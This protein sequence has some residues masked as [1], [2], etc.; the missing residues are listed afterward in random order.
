MSRNYTTAIDYWGFRCPKGGD[1]YICENAWIEFIGCCNSDP[2]ADGTGICQNGVEPLSFDRKNSYKLPLQTCLSSS[3]S[4]NFYLCW[5][6]S[7]PFMGCC[8]QNACGNGCPAAQPGTALLSLNETSRRD[9]FYP[10]SLSLPVPPSSKKF[11][12]PPST[13]L[14]SSFKSLEYDAKSSRNG[15]LMQ[16]YAVHKHVFSSIKCSVHKRKKG[17]AKTANEQTYSQIGNQGSDGSDESMRPSFTPSRD[18]AIVADRRFESQ[19][20]KLKQVDVTTF[21]V[22]VWNIVLTLV[23][24]CFIGR[25]YKNLARYCLEQSGGVRLVVLEQ[26]FGSQSFATALERVF[27]VHTHIILSFIIL[28]TWT[29]SPLGGQSSSRILGFGNATEVANGTVNYLHPA[30]QVSSYLARRS[31]MATKSSVAALYSS[32]LLSSLEQKCSPRDMWE[33]PKIPQIIGYRQ[34][35]K[36]YMVDREALESGDQH[37]ASLLGVQLRGL[38]PSQEATEHNFTVQTSYID[39]DCKLIDDRFD[40]DTDYWKNKTTSDRKDERV[41]IDVQ[42]PLPWE[43]LDGL[44]DPPPLQLLYFS[45]WPYKNG[46][47][48]FTWYWSAMNCTM[49]TIWLETD[50]HCGQRPSSTSCHAHQQRQLKDIQHANRPPRLMGQNYGA[51]QQALRFWP[52]ASG[53]G[54][55]DG[56]LATENYIMGELHPYAGHP[57]RNWTALDLTIFPKEVSKRLTTAFNTFWDATLNPLGHT[58]VSFGALNS[59]NP[60]YEDE[61]N[62]EPFMNATVGTMTRTFEVYRASQLWVAILLT[63][64]MFLQI[65]AILGLILEAVIVGPE[66]LGFA[67]SLTR[68]NPY[69]PVPPGNSAVGGAERARL[70]R[71]LRLQIADLELGEENGYIAVHALQKSNVEKVSTEDSEEQTGTDETSGQVHTKPLGRGR[72]YR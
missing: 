44:D 13:L 16:T 6:T 62:P 14:P 12:K 37:Y 71:D 35:R 18:E 25:F 31:L 57:Y 67:S 42:S 54:G 47:N 43:E 68:D 19:P 5:G 10:S 9:L 63:T 20:R 30:Y 64:T 34:V 59:S 8:G 17:P 53:D 56:P 60:A 70:F 26:I 36:T 55:F 72:L 50:I 27:L 45:N 46:E 38:G 69:V 22:W 33:L 41:L 3:S 49:R 66:V 23:P 2:C 32:N 39:L 1:F 61:F 4:D 65:L 15:S 28:T 11:L 48:N 29:L 40:L 24:M 7:P 51:L 58:N 52:E 21:I